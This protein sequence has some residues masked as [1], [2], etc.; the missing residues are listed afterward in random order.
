MNSKKN[1]FEYRGFVSGNTPVLLKIEHD[2]YNPELISTELILLGSQEDHGGAFKASLSGDEHGN[3][4]IK[5]ENNTDNWVT[6]KNLQGWSHQG[7][8]ANI[9]IES[10]EYAFSEAPIEEA[11]NIYVN[12]E[13]TPSV[14]LK[15]SCLRELSYDGSI[16]CKEGYPEEIEWEFKFGK[17]KAFTRYTYE[18]DNV[19]DNKSTIQIERPSLTFEINKN[20]NVSSHDIKNAVLDEARDFSLILSLCYR[21]TVSWYEINMTVI[22]KDR[23]LGVVN[24]LIR[25]KVYSK[26]YPVHGNE[27]INHRDLINGGLSILVNNFRSSPIIES[28]RRSITFLA[29]SQSNQTIE[30][31]FFQSIISL[32]SFCDGFFEH[33]KENVNIPSGKWKK[34]ERALRDSLELL[35][36][37]QEMSSYVERVKKKLPELKGITTLDKVLHCCKKLRVP[38]TDLWEKEGFE[39]GLGKAL[40]M[41]NHLFHRAYCEDPYFLYANFVRIQILT[42]RL[43]LK[44]FEWPDEKIWRWYDQEMRRACID[45]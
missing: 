38:T 17:G 39:S 19:Y 8:N 41:R 3:L 27:L 5:G 45:V 35:S 4:T 33:N 34:I 28:L 9:Y 15:K 11:E 20:S 24:P 43:I 23:T 18:E 21:K 30:L 44:H 13:L 2:K 10:Y 22:P 29:S 42:E 1:N 36:D 40:N 31:K 25:R 7:S 37:Q 6:L 16:S 26:T 14:I 12:V 32:E